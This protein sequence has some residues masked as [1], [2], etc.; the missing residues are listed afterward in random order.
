MKILAILY[1]GGEIAKNNPGLLGCAENALGLRDFL[2]KQGHEFVVLTDKEHKLDEHLSTTEILITTPFWPAYITKE[3]IS[4]APMLRLILT[5]G[6]GS[7]HVGLQAA[8]ERG[9]TVAE[10]TGSN[11]VGVAEQ[12]VM[13]ILALVRTIYPHTNRFLMVDGILQK[14]RLTLMIW[15][16]RLLELLW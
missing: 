12:I 16:T 10:I 2:E 1:P 5:A 4:K 9:I 15:K 13:H 3:R 14:L 11:V 6:V 8:P 7:D